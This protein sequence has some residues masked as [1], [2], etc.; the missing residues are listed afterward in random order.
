M[1]WMTVRVGE[2]KVISPICDTVLATKT[3]D[4]DRDYIYIYD[5]SKVGWS[6]QKVKSLVLVPS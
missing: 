1:T 2:E 5:L 6:T 3:K 4:Y